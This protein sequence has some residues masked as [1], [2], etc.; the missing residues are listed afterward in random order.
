[1]HIVGGGILAKALSNSDRLLSDGVQV[2]EDPRDKG[3]NSD[4]LG[5]VVERDGTTLLILCLVE[6]LGCLRIERVVL[7]VKGINVDADDIVTH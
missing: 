2:S 3:L 4:L 5:I 7:P 1:L 6:V